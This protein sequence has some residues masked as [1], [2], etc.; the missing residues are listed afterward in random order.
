M[1]YVGLHEETW[2]RMHTLEELVGPQYSFTHYGWSGS[3]AM[4]ITNKHGTIIAVLT[5]H[6]EDPNWDRVHKEVADHLETT[7][8]AFTLTKKQRTH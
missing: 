2:K 5:G 4:P 1:A 3:V 8:H 6:P 7:C